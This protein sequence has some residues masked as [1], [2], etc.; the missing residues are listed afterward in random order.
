MIVLKKTLLTVLVYII[1]SFA[2]SSDDS[3]GVRIQDGFIDGN[4]F[5]GHSAQEKRFYAIGVIEGMLLSPIFGAPKNNLAWFEDCVVGMSAR[6]VVAIFEKFLSEN[7]GR[8][9]ESMH[10]LSYAAMLDACK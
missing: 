1:A 3:V 6:Q 8:W 4:E 10:G 5:L 7:L 2:I 9:H